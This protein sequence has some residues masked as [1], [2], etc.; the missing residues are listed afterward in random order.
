MNNLLPFTETFN[1]MAMES[2]VGGHFE[3]DQRQLVQLHFKELS[4]I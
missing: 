3:A 2:T 4:F 1:W